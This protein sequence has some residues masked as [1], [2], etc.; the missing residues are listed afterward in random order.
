MRHA[1]IWQIER[2]VEFLGGHRGIRG[3]HDHIATIDA[4]QQSLGM[5]HVTLLLYILKVLC[6]SLLVFQT[7]LVR[8]EHNIA[9]GNAADDI[10]LT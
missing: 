2:G 3:I 1:G 8:M 6:L 9:I 5:H 7:F 4:L 10:F